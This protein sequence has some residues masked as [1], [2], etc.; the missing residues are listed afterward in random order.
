MMGFGAVYLREIRSAAGTLASW[1][2][3]AVAGFLVSLVFIVMVLVPSGPVTL[4]PVMGVSAWIL[5]LVAPAMAMRSFSDE[6]RQG[7]WEI[8]Q[9][10]PINALGIV[11]GKFAANLCQLVLLGVPIV[12]LG[13]IL[14]IY[15][16]PDWGEIGC[17]LLGLFL[18]GSC[19]LALGMLASTASESQLVSYL[20]G[21]VQLPGPG[22]AH[23]FAALVGA[24]GLGTHALLDRPDPTN[25][26]LRT[27]SP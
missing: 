9:T 2:T 6:R 17:G 25:Q 8:L 7:T 15:G 27:G 12:I 24:C 23:S 10:A 13:L 16:R 14:E 4:Q 3:L 19:W 18:A 5:L 1:T 21:I 20:A 11:L 22:P 26:R